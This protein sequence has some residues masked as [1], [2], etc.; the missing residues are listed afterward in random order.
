M[1][2]NISLSC[3]TNATEAFVGNNLSNMSG[4]PLSYDWRSKTEKSLENMKSLNEFL[5]TR[6]VGDL[7]L[8]EIDDYASH[9]Q[10]LMKEL[11]SME[12]VYTTRQAE[13]ERERTEWAE[14]RSSRATE[15]AN[16]D[17]DISA[18]KKA[19]DEAEAIY[20][21]EKSTRASELKDVTDK[22]CQETK[23][24]ETLKGKYKTTMADTQTK[25]NNA[26][27]ELETVRQTVTNEKATYLSA[28]QEREHTLKE[29]K[30]ILKERKHTLKERK[31]TLKKREYTLKELDNKLAEAHSNA[32]QKRGAPSETIMK[33]LRQEHAQLQTKSDGECKAFQSLQKNFNELQSYLAGL[34]VNL[35]TLRPEVEQNLANLMVAQKSRDET[36]RAHLPQTSTKLSQLRTD[37]NNPISE[38][39]ALRKKEN[40]NSNEISQLRAINE[41][42]KGS[43]IDLRQQST[44]DKESSPRL[45]EQKSQRSEELDRPRLVNEG[46]TDNLANLRKKTER[47]SEG[48]SRLRT[49]SISFANS[50]KQTALLGAESDL[51]PRTSGSRM[52]ANVQ[53][54]LSTNSTIGR[55]DDSI[56]ISDHDD[57]ESDF[58]AYGEDDAACDMSTQPTK[59]RQL[60]FS[61]GS[62]W[63]IPA[64]EGKDNASVTQSR[65][66][67]P[68]Q[69]EKIVRQS[70]WESSWL[71]IGLPMLQ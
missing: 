30:H 17:N 46:L 19:R 65:Q 56:W 44:R 33:G 67:I 32:T 60:A 16:L 49:T 53:E 42:R 59:R 58:V 1:G 25:L 39:H 63:K 20:G 18:K 5:A 55:R 64:S 35:D 3:S 6:K 37:N 10:Q 71:D 47:D 48:H 22:I 27:Q 51:L 8:N 50:R 24:L 28:K 57:S 23:S 13:M 7:R 41:G 45:R 36:F 12:S 62:A 29:R 40:Q 69:L 31:H 9:A 38:L 14:A 26:I 70:I 2:D 21:Q 15:L 52:R 34:Q 43:I 11:E 54:S 61:S 4:D 68:A 66:A